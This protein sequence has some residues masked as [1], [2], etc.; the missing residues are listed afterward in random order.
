MRWFGG[1]GAGGGGSN[2]LIWRDGGGFGG[3]VRV[4]FIC[5]PRGWKISGHQEISGGKQKSGSGP[6]METGKSRGADISTDR[7][8][9]FFAPFVLGEFSRIDGRRRSL[10]LPR[11]LPRAHLGARGYCSIHS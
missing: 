4:I 7:R 1:F 9:H 2:R 11:V 5:V 6:K 3:A 8:S 10:D